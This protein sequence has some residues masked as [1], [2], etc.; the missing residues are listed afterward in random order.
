VC[1]TCGG[2]FD[3]DIN[4]ARNILVLGTSPTGGPPG[5]ACGSSQTIGRK[6]EE[7]SREG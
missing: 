7:D 2:D 5:M 3:A 6:Q 4:G 1:T